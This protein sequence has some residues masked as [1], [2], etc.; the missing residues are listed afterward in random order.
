[1]KSTN[2][3]FVEYM[4]IDICFLC[5]YYNCDVI[6][7]VIPDMAYSNSWTT[8]YR[9]A[10]LQWPRRRCHYQQH[11]YRLLFDDFYYIRFSYLQ[12]ILNKLN[13]LTISY[14]LNVSD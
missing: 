9:G 10:F 11:T 7:Y 6:D 8:P 14:I 13:E 12:H 2:E 1:M 3:M 4:V 5:Q